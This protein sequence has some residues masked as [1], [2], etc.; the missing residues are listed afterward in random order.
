MDLNKLLNNYIY[1]KENVV[2]ACTYLK[3]SG[4]NFN[5]SILYVDDTFSNRSSRQLDLP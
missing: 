5:F 3:V 4:S 1:Q 2:D